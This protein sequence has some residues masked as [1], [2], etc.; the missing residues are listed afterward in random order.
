MT[1]FRAVLV[2]CLVLGAAVSDAQQLAPRLATRFTAGVTALKAGQLADAERAFR[3]V[4]AAGGNR[5]FVHHNLGIALEQGGH[6]EAALA[7]FRAAS[8]LDPSFAPARLMA[9]S[10]LLALGRP[11]QAVSE[12]RKAVALTPDDRASHEQLAAALERTGDVG[13]VVDEYRRLVALAPASEEYAY[14]LGKSYLKLAQWSYERMRA[15][16]PDSARLAQAL[17]EQQLAQGRLDLAVQSFERAARLD[18]SLA[19]IHLALARLH[20]DARR[21]D[22]AEAEVNRALALAPESLVGARLKAAIQA[23]RAQQR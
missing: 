5:A 13:G 17:G 21:W 8:A 15:I 11:K 18:P 19:D 23:A 9:G 22:E 10:T 4:L 7:E 1:V 20:L 2:A 14:R 3:D 16:D 12:L 6:H